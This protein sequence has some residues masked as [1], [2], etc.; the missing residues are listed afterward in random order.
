MLIGEW[1]HSARYAFF[2]ITQYLVSVSSTNL[3]PLIILGFIFRDTTQLVIYT[4]LLSLWYVFGLWAM[5]GF[6][7]AITVRVG[8]LL[9][10]HE[11]KNAFRAAIFSIFYGETVALILS[12]LVFTLSTPLSHLFTTDID[13]ATKLALNIQGMSFIILCNCQFITQGILNGC[14]LQG[15]Q[16]IVKFSTRV[17]LGITLAAIISSLVEWKALGIFLGNG[18]GSLATFAINMIIILSRSWKDIAR[19]VSKNTQTENLHE[20]EM[21]ENHRICFCIKLCKTPKLC[22]STIW[23][24]KVF[25]ICRYFQVLLYFISHIIEYCLLTA[26]SCILKC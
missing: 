5:G 8:N 16:A 17:F 14:S 4:V 12:T 18:I 25:K 20:E 22:E 3:T 9:G 19:N 15:T 21:E 24:S 10:A 2:P 6:S 7:S 13:F 23:E 11:Y 1:C 26:T